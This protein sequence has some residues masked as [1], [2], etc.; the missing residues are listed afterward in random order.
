MMA[1]AEWIPPKGIDPGD[2]LRQAVED[3]NNGEYGLA[4][5]KHIWFLDHALEIDEAYFG[6]RLSYNLDEWALLGDKYPPAKLALV[7]KANLAKTEIEEGS[8]NV[9]DAFHDFS[10]INEY[11]DST[12]D[13]IKLFE[14]LDRNAPD[15]ASKV[16]NLA[17][18]ALIDAHEYVIIGKY[19]DVQ[20]R[21]KQIN[22]L[23]D[24][25]LKYLN[26]PEMG[27]GMLEYSEQSYTY[28]IG[29][30]VAV[31][32]NLDRRDEAIEVVNASSGKVLNKEYE[33]TINSALAGNPPPKWP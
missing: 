7:T 1:S 25:H 10:S 31:L 24:T 33:S 6:V 21:L 9:R 2:V 4:L 11:I 17:F 15:K 27:A 28:G 29:S 16:F 26:D 23:Y 3:R 19:I 20:K 30:L 14:W 5:D 12:Q 32:V 13:T 22:K 18:P 8:G